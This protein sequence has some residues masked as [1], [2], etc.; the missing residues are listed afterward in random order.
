[1]IQ[2]KDILK[3]FNSGKIKL[4]LNKFYNLLKGRIFQPLNRFE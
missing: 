2:A 4:K 1:M 3:N